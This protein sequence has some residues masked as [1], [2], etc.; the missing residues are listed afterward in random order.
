MNTPRA[1]RFQPERESK[2]RSEADDLDDLGGEPLD[3]S[4][5]ENEDPES[6]FEERS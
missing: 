6:D 5:F 2:A 1:P 3:G 4:G